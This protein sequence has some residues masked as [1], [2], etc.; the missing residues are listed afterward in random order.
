MNA[1]RGIRKMNN[2]AITLI[3]VTIMIISGLF[4][5]FIGITIPISTILSIGMLFL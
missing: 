4:L 1:Y 5:I 3:I 2:E